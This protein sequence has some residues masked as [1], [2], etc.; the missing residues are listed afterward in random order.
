MGP[1]PQ[2][3]YIAYGKGKN[4]NFVFLFLQWSKYIPIN[5]K[6][7]PKTFNEICEGFRYPRAAKC[8]EITIFDQKQPFE[9]EKSPMG[10]CR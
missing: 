3:P 4:W 1:L 9:T 8:E 5:L 7:T 6:G 10:V 2:I